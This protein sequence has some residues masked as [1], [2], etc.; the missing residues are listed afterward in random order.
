MIGPLPVAESWVIYLPS[1]VGHSSKLCV[2]A[3]LLASKLD[4]KAND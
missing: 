2:L 4:G 3:Q 1:D